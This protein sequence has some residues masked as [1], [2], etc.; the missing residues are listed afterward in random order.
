MSRLICLLLGSIA[1]VVSS[2]AAPTPANPDTQEPADTEK[3][4][5]DSKQTTPAASAASPEPPATAA[6]PA[7]PPPAA[8]TPPPAPKPPATPTSTCD[9]ARDIGSVKADDGGQITAQGTCAEWLQ[10]TAVESDGG[11]FGTPMRLKVTLTNPQG[12]DFDLVAFMNRNQNV[13][14]CGPL[15]IAD[16]EHAGST[17]EQFEFSWGE[18]GF[19]AND[20][21]DS[22]I[23]M[24]QIKNASGVCTTQPWQLTVEGN[25]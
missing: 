22:R 18:T 21:D 24:I 6:P 20:V 3:N 16:S 25:K 9:T 7:A 15:A 8:T 23:V 14:D 5:S 12:A 1:C 13:K 11:F 10:L 19:A 2:C 17:N 4:P